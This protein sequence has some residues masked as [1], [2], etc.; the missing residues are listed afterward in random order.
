MDNKSTNKSTN[1]RKQFIN[2][3]GEAANKLELLYLIG[4]FA[5]AVFAVIDYFV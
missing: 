5:L 3:V 4:I 2:T 1:W